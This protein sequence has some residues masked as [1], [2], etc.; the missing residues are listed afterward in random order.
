[1]PLATGGGT[2]VTVQK[3]LPLLERGSSIILTSSNIDT[4]GAASFVTRGIRVNSIAPGPVETPGLS[5]LA[6]DPGSAEQLLKGLAAGVPMNGLGRPEEIAETVLVLAS[7]ASS[8]MTGAEIHVVD[9]GASQISQPCS[10]FTVHRSL[11]EHHAQR[12]RPAR[13][14]PARGLRQPRPPL[15]PRGDRAHLHRGRRV[16][17]SGGRH[18][19]LGRSGGQGAHPAREGPRQLRGHRGQPPLRRSARRSTRLGLRSRRGTRGAW[20]RHHHRPGRQDRHPHGHTATRPQGSW[21]DSRRSIRQAE[22]ALDHM[23]RAARASSARLSASRW[24]KSPGS[25]PVCTK[26][27]RSPG[28]MSPSRTAATRPAMARPV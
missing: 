7:D 6:D 12:D 9:G 28:R 15:P 5:G 14:R 1:M 19:G 2:L 21:S 11:K 4:K 27:V 17:R 13:G 20:H 22:R 3:A 18:H 8:Y 26:T 16:H 23:V 25:P 24:P 10:A